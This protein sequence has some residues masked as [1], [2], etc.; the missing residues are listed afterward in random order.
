MHA[1]GRAHGRMHMH[2]RKLTMYQGGNLRALCGF[3]ATEAHV[4]YG[5]HAESKAA[6]AAAKESAVHGRHRVELQL[7]TASCKRPT[8]TQAARRVKEEGGRG[9]DGAARCRFET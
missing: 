2:V 1:Q 8:T 9:Q 4:G 3:N 5:A 7:A 6:A